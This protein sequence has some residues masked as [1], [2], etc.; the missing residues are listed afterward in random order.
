MAYPTNVLHMATE[1]GNKGHSAAFPKTL[2][3]W[4]I[5]LFT[6]EGDIVLDPFAGS[7]TTLEAAQKLGRNSIGIEI[8]RAFYDLMRENAHGRFEQS[9]LFE[10]AGAQYG[11]KNYSR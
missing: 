5:N 7:G 10:S 3:A 6:R 8:D 2:P 4:F 11:A 9:M 1:C